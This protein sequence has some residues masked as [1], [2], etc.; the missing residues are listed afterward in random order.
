VF[1][2]LLLT[3]AIGCAS[4]LGLGRLDVDLCSTNSEAVHLRRGLI[5]QLNLARQAGYR[6][7]TCKA[8]QNVLKPAYDI[9]FRVHI[10]L[11]LILA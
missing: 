7:Y 8:L 6:T 2:R 10:L 9:A 3:L 4:W 11:V 1:N 5:P